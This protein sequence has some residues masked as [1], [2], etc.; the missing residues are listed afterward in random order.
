MKSYSIPIVRVAAIGALFL[1]RV[2][3]AQQSVYTSTPA[4]DIADTFVTNGTLSGANTSANY[5]GAGALMVTGSASGNGEFESLIKFDLSGAKA[6]FDAQFGVGHWTI[7]NVTLTLKSNFA[8]QGGQPNNPIFPKINLGGF[9]VSWLANDSWTEGPATANPSSPSTYPST[10]GSLATDVTFSNLESFVSASDEVVGY[11]QYVPPGN[12]NNVP[13]NWI[14]GTGMADAGFVAD[15]AAGNN[16]SLL[17][18]PTDQTVSYLF[19]SRTKYGNEPFI[20]V[21]AVPEPGTAWLML[22]GLASAVIF[23]RRKRW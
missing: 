3:F 18:S 22:A 19:N 13:L 17:F 7:S 21:T 8:T 23:R 20:T 2:T 12:N 16:V 15:I 9:S 10:P 6:Q 5:G 14:L 1:A 11:F 4:N